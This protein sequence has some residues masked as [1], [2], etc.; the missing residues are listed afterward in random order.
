[1]SDCSR[2]LPLCLLGTALLAQQKPERWWTGTRFTPG[3]GLRALNID[4]AGPGGEA[5]LQTSIAS[6]VFLALNLESPRLALNEQFSLSVLGHAGTVNADHQWVNNSAASTGQDGDGHR[7]SLGTS[8]SGHYRY[9]AP[10]LTWGH[11]K[12]GKGGIELS[13]GLGW[14]SGQF[15]GNA[16]FAPNNVANGAMPRT[17]VSVGFSQLGYDTRIGLHGKN[18]CLITT[19]GG[20]FP[21]NQNGIR[22]QFQQI[23]V[24]VGYE[25]TL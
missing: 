22:Y 9:L 2:I 5:N 4:L 17:P 8:L 24:I 21:F 3:V 7:E 23:A 25:F 13:V 18:W 14:W 11:R 16:I 19:V 15:S 20:P 12:P 1:M 6:S 10:A